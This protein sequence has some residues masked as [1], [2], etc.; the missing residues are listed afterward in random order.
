MLLSLL[1]KEDVLIIL[2]SSALSLL[3]KSD[4]LFCDTAHS[5]VQFNMNPYAM[6]SS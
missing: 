6:T 3:I 4:M 2:V 1:I 5:T